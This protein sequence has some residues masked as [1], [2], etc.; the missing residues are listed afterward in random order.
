MGGTVIRAMTQREITQRADLL[1]LRGRLAEH[2]R[3][4]LPYAGY[5]WQM[6]ND[7]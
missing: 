1:D 6:S 5:G 2:G 4:R 3:S 7:Q